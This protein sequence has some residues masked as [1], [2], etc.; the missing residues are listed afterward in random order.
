MISLGPFEPDRGLF[1]PDVITNVI[2]CLPVTDGWGPMPDLSVISTALGTACLG[3]VYVRTTTGS[4]RVI[5]GTATALYEFDTSTLGWTD[6][7][8]LAGGAYA[9]PAGDNWSFQPFGLYLVAVNLA[10]D[11]QY[12][13]IGSGANF[14]A[15]PGSPPKAKYAWVSG[16][17]L[18][19]GHLAS[20]PN[21]LQTSGIGDLSF[22]T[23][24]QRGCDIQD[25]AEGEE[26]VGGI[27]AER[28]AVV[29]HR[30]IIRQ[31]VIQTGG[32][33]SFSTSILNPS[34]GVV[35]PLSIASIGPGR[36]V[37][38]SSDG[39]M[40]GAEGTPI[41]RNRVDK[42]FEGQIA[43]QFTVQAMVDPYEQIVWFKGTRADTTGFLLGYDWGENRWCYS[44]ALIEFMAALVT[45]GVTINGMDAY[46][47]TFDDASE[48]FDSRLFTGGAATMAVFDTSHRLCYL[49]GGNRAATLQTADVALSGFNKR[50]FLQKARVIGDLGTSYTLKAITADYHGGTRTTGSA[51]TPYSATAICHFRSSALTHALL[52]EIP[53]NTSWEHVAAIEPT[54]VT[55]GER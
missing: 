15:I 40:M 28:G 44:D 4:Y 3:A 33:F 45:P 37:Y 7:S 29:F 13:D 36:F 52:L 26:I 42:W 17:F 51:I 11:P 49:T 46:Y 48:P 24:G 34:R 2:N 8:R 12:L 9:V 22:W 23:I 18:V 50:S 53:A 19:L 35:A 55:E 1:A 39:F 41:G 16:E 32:D 25:F 43:S 31:M 14:A 47:S 38:Y 10:D 30:T 54:F 20:F 21:K 5:A 6:I 27:G